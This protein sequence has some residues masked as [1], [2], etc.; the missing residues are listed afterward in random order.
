MNL[1]KLNQKLWSSRD[2]DVLEPVNWDRRILT[3]L[4]RTFG[5]H[6]SDPKFIIAAS[7]PATHAIVNKR[8]M[9]IEL[10]RTAPE[11]SWNDDW[12]QSWPGFNY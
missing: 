1:S 12:N 8:T 10:E 11:V 4:N 2:P 9:E 7:A 3:S 5:L 6:P